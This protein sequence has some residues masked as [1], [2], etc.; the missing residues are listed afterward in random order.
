MDRQV[1]FHLCH[2]QHHPLNFQK[3]YF[4]L[5]QI[6][7]IILGGGSSNGFI[8]SKSCRIVLQSSG[9][10]LHRLVQSRMPERYTDRV[11][12]YDG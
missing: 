4:D 9:P 12:K 11:I 2:Y 8:Y 6:L 10:S 3:K 5:V 1:K 7:L